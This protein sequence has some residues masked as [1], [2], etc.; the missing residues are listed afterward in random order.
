[1]VKQGQPFVEAGAGNLQGASRRVNACF[2][3]G[4]CI[5]RN[6]L[7]GGKAQWG[8]GG[9]VQRGISR[10]QWGVRVNM[11]KRSSRTF[12][13][14]GMSWTWRVGRLLSAA[15]DSGRSCSSMVDETHRMAV[16]CERDLW[17]RRFS[18]YFHFRLRTHN[19]HGGAATTLEAPGSRAQ[20]LRLLWQLPHRAD[21]FSLILRS[22]LSYGLDHS[23]SLG[24]GRSISMKRQAAGSTRRHLSAPA[25]RGYSCC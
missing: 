10:S 20:S 7:V 4:N 11:L 18:N 16:L 21:Q 9:R 22:L 6:S 12:I 23:S 24:Q 5:R 2:L 14:K 17:R 15:A 8:P 3:A 13:A 1:M 25:R 19:R